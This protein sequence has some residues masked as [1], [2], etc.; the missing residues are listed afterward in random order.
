MIDLS[1]QMIYRIGNLDVQNERIS[2]QMSTGKVLQNGSDDSVL[3]GRY[4]NV[5][6]KL[7]D[8]E[9]IKIQLDKTVAQNNVSDQTIDE[10]KLTLDSVKQDLLKALNSGMTRSDREAVATNISGMREN[11]L[12][13]ANTQIDGEYIFAGSNTT[14]V[15]YSKDADYV[16][17]GQ[18]DFNGNAHLRN[19]AVDNGTY[20][21]RGVS[22][23]D[24]FMYTS[25]TTAVDNKVSFTKQEMVVDQNG[26][27]WKL[28]SAGDKLEK[29][30]QD[31]TVTSGADWEYLDVNGDSNVP[32]TFTTEDITTALNIKN[33]TKSGLLLEAK[34]N[35]FDDLNIIINALNGYKTVENDGVTNGERDSLATDEEV[36]NILS[37][38]LGKIDDQYS[39][40]NIGHAE[41]GGRNKIFE[42][43]LE[44]TTAKITHYNILLQETNGADLAKLAMESKSLEMTYNALFS[45]VSKMSQMSLVNFLK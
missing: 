45:T 10:V 17:N 44:S 12:R 25:D 24:I 22:A 34:H 42:T 31:G 35:V 9:G 19:I 30:N 21:E 13:L 6:N 32:E 28:N 39:A 3:Y 26:Y 5:E 7:R 14:V 27:S 43:Y 2:Y 1:N 4:L 15:P 40:T 8:A 18:I 20:R 38:Y 37:N 33:T 16:I 11:L 29:Y 41:L 23:T 36:R